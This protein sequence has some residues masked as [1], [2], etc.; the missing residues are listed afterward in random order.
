MKA[1][2]GMPV[3]VRL[4]DGLGVEFP[5]D[6]DPGL[7]RARDRG[8]RSIPVNLLRVLFYVRIGEAIKVLRGEV[9]LDGLV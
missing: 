2:S 8:T 5:T 6:L 4:S 3:R 1:W 7:D 9:S